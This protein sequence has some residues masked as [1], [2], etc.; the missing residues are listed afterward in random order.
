[1][2]FID[3][4]WWNRPIQKNVSGTETHNGIPSDMLPHA[5]QPPQWCGALCPAGS[6]SSGGMDCPAHRFLSES[7]GVRFRLLFLTEPHCMVSALTKMVCG[8][9]VLQV[10]MPHSLV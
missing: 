7:V 5:I 3:M 1:M 10:T 9:L 6:S 4:E 2:T 8:K